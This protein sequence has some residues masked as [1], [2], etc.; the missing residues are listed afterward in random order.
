MRQASRERLSA[1]GEGLSGIVFW[2]VQPRI[3]EWSDAEKWLL[4]GLHP[5]KP[6]PTKSTNRAAIQKMRAITKPAMPLRTLNSFASSTMHF[7]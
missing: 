7:E 3:D 4:R 5:L 6:L 2:Y 1:Q